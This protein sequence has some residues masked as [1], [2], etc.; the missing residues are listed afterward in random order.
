VC[1]KDVTER[2]GVRVDTSGSMSGFPI[3]QAK[4]LISRALAMNSTLAIHST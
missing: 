3:E 4:K 2:A 1:W